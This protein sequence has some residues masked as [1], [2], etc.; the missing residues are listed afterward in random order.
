[1]KPR[2]PDVGYLKLI[3]R[4]Q[5]DGWRVE[6][7]YLALPSAE[8]PRLRV[9]ERVAHGGHTITEIDIGRPFQRSLYN[10]LNLFAPKVNQAEC[11]EYWCTS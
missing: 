9:V 3:E 2:L 4:L 10:M 1:L 5:A 11:Y 7:I 6:L 8:M